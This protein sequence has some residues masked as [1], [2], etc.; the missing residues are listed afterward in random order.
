MKNL[1][2]CCLFIAFAMTMSVQ[3][4]EPAR[5]SVDF[6][7]SNGI[8]KP[9]NGVN[10]WA[11]MSN[12]RYDD[13]Q[14]LMTAARFSTI[15]L[16]DAP[17]DNPG[18]RLV[19]VQHIFGN[20]KADAKNPDN[21]Y[22]LQTDDYIKRILEGGSKVIYRLGTSIE[23]TSP[24]FYYA[25]EPKDH[26]QFAEVCAGIIRHYNEG[27]AD[28]FNWNIEYWEIWNEPDGIPNM[29]D[30]RDFAVFCQFY[31]DVAKRL[32]KEFPKIKIGGPA[33]CSAN[34]EKIAQL[35]KFCKEQNAPLDF[36]SWHCYT[37]NLNAITES[38]SR[39]RKLL[40]ENGFTKTELH[41]NE[42]H[43]FPA[44]WNEIH[45]K[46][47]TPASRSKLR[48]GL[49][50]MNGIDSA[51]FCAA[52]LTRWQDLPITMGNYYAASLVGET[53]WGLF[54]DYGTPFKT[55]YAFKMFGEFIHKAPNRVK[56]TD[57][58]KSISLLGATGSNDCKML[59]ISGFLKDLNGLEIQL[60]GVPQEGK[61]SVIRLDS[62]E[63]EKAETISYSKGSIKLKTAPGSAVL[64][65]KWN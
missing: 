31:V 16:H 55:Y 43:Y 63:N 7:K 13:H 27:W 45:G 36:L 4:A 17:W 24:Q 2:L 22:F 50:G 56:T 58:G 33:L 52:V 9:V 28:G 60:N 29:W 14:E 10:L 46:G 38:S 6:G 61:V 62:N 49:K 32:R 47:W 19:D 40:N 11:R 3:A 59:L 44:N 8:V 41:L 37:N 53:D 20:A 51:A 26:A 1:I 65:L 12:A 15:R 18:L 21:Y 39:V 30:T 57:D 54:D 48:N 5:Y 42:W 64:L 23:H 34:Q 25:K 35:I